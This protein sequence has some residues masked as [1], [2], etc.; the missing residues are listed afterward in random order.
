YRTSGAAKLEGEY[1][2]GTPVGIWR[3]ADGLGNS[4]FEV[5]VGELER[6]E[7][8]AALSAFSNRPRGADE[9]QEQ[10]LELIDGNRFVEAL[11]CL[12]RAV[13][14]SCEVEVM[15]D[16][17][18]RFALPTHRDRSHELF[19]EVAESDPLTLASGLV[20]GANAAAV[21]RGLAI[22]LD[23][24]NYGHAALDF[25]NAAI[26]LEPARSEYLFTRALVLMRLG[27]NQHAAMDIEELAPDEPGQAGFLRSYNGILFPSFDF[28]P[29]RE[30]PET[31]YDGLP[32]GPSQPL[33][34]VRAVIQKYARRVTLIRDAMGTY[35]SSD[36]EWFPPDVSHLF[37]GEEGELVQDSFERTDEDGDTED[38]DV[39]ETLDTDDAELPDLLRW[40]RSEWNALTYLCWAVGLDEVAMPNAIDPRTG[41]GDAAG[42]AVQRLWRC[43]DRR[44]MGGYGAQRSGA[45]GFEWEGID[46]DEIPPQLISIAES[47]YAEMAAMFRWLTDSDHRSP[48]QD[49]LRGS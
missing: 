41:F 11:L 8:L 34:A 1:K 36:I 37:S 13:A 17:L 6:V 19:A 5:S 21:L 43:R 14:S 33:E 10:A 29:N 31:Y 44:M 4:L 49:D 35:V 30:P 25:V 45:P 28:W 24:A 7:D 42:M 22:H 20:L 27:L 48:W 2:E 40:A 46:V 26:L 15:L 47:Q 39:D 16:G 18:K 23:Q 3:L 9:W 12:S 38:V 32:D